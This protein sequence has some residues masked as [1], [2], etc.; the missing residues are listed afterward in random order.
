MPLALTRR[1]PT[2]SAAKSCRASISIRS[3][4]SPP[5]STELVRSPS[6][7]TREASS[8]VTGESSLGPAATAGAAP[9]AGSKLS[10]R[11]WRPT[12]PGSP[13][14]AILPSAI[15]IA[16]WQYSST[17]AISWVTRTIVLPAAFISWKASAHFCWKAASPTASTSSI[18]RMSASTSSISEKA[19]RTSI[20][21]E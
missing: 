20:P 13:I 2:L 1:Y 12:S 9:S 5:C 18:R 7:S 11:Y 3:R 15:S 14:R 16:R 8:I 19:S 17:V 21:E 4:S 6:A 10:R